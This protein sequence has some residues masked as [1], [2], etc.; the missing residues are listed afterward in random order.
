MIQVYFNIGHKLESICSKPICA[1]TKQG[2]TCEQHFLVGSKF[3]DPNFPTV[4]KIPELLV[5]LCPNDQIWFDH[6]EIGFQ[7]CIPKLYTF[8]HH[9]NFDEFHLKFF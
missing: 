1:H 9:A 6:H 7:L 5:H 3:P 8:D 2:M 4:V